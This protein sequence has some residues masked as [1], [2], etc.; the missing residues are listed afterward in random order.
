MPVK[1]LVWVDLGDGTR[2][3]TATVNGVTTSAVAP[4]DRALTAEPLYDH[5]VRG[6]RLIDQDGRTWANAF[7]RHDCS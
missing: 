2:Q 6:V 7:V 4:A 3:W 1:R 5:V